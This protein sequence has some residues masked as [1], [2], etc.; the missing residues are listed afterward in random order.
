[1]NYDKFTLKA[2]DAIQAANSIAQQ[3][4]HSEIGTEHLLLAL[5]EQEDGVVPPLIERIGVNLDRLKDQVEELLDTYPRVTGG[6]QIHFS[7]EASKV[8][9]KA[10]KET[11][12]LKDEYLSTEHILLEIGRASCRERV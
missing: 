1:M 12:S 3:E 5:L 2:Q 7:N 9:A 11:A 6:A 4:D 8:I 10:E